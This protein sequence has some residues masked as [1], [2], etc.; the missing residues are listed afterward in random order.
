MMN[1]LLWGE[2]AWSSELL[3]DLVNPLIANCKQQTKT[4]QHT[5]STAVSVSLS[6]AHFE[7]HVTR[8]NFHYPT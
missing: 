8:R 2:A 3:P 7:E 4:T 1:S 5:R 6:H